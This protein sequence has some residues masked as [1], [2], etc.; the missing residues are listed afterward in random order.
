MNEFKGHKKRM[1]KKSFILDGDECCEDIDVEM[2]ADKPHGFGAHKMK[3]MMCGP[4]M[5]GFAFG[6]GGPHKKHGGHIIQQ[7]KDRARRAGQ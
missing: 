7:V 3:K 1:F 2:F 4:D 5:H 6:M